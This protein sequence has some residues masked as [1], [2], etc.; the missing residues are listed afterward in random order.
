MKKLTRILLAIL[1]TVCVFSGISFHHGHEHIHVHAY[2]IGDIINVTCPECGCTT[3][4]FD[5]PMREPTC[6]EDG[7]AWVY[8]TE[9]E[10][11]WEMTLPA[12]GHDYQYSEEFSIEPTCT[13][14]GVAG[15][16]CSRC[17]EMTRETVSALGHNYTSTVTKQP[18]CTEAG[19]RTYSCT[20]CSNSYTASIA[21][22]G[23]DYASVVTKEA[24]CTE[25]GI[26]TF[27]CNNCGDHYEEVIE[28]LGH[29]YGEY[30]VTK[31]A[32]CT[33]DG[34][35]E[36]TCSRCHDTLS[37]VIPMTGHA[38]SSEWTIEKEPGLLTKGLKSQICENCQEKIYE[39]IPAK[40]PLPVAIV[41]VTGSTAALAA[42]VYFF[43]HS[44]LTGAKEVVTKVLF[45]PTLED[46]TVVITAEDEEIIEQLKKQFFLQVNP[47][48]P[49]DLAQS[50]EDNGP[51]IVICE[52]EDKETIEGIVE[53]KKEKFPDTYL[54]L[55]V[56][57]EVL[58]EEKDSLDRLKKQDV[59]SS[60]VN[61]S[62]N[63]YDQMVKLILPTLKPELDSCTTLENI[64]QL[65]DL[66]G[67]PGVSTII[68]IY[69]SG[70]DIKDTLDA[71]ELGISEQATII[72]DIAS[73]LGLDT[74]ESVAGLVGDVKTIKEAMDD[75][76][77]N[78]EKKEGATA[79]KDI[80]DVISD[81]L[82]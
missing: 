51:D 33:E 75:E 76:S 65:A 71:G 44:V 34:L 24:T 80:S 1:L 79:V 39:D 63:K 42:I 82:D 5:D 47:C 67:I 46:K 9:N 25:S 10:H 12:L 11:G 64:G 3:A 30:V 77:G 69:N 23:H 81:L 6:T 4:V 13:D 48:K 43:K 74:L 31:E 60:Y 41:V 61:A 20:R 7:L 22:T 18:T 54:G 57:E 36:S 38:Y 50:V 27:T 58:A 62:S 70:K 59:I 55:I 26:T 72:G 73:I 15:Y 53:L 16:V 8:C 56:A 32:T 52:C 35:K 37:E 49:E 68:S 45:K 29:D 17:G 28:A 21:A 2:E 14:S 78:Y 66:L 40:V 19:L